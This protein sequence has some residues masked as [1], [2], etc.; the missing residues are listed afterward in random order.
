MPLFYVDYDH[1]NEQTIQFL[2]NVNK[3]AIRVNCDMGYL[4]NHKSA[5]L[6]SLALTLNIIFH[7][8]SPHLLFLLK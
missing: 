4:K 7:D 6:L 8:G 5:S 1:N 3:H 2:T